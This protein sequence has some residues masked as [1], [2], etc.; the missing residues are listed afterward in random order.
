MMPRAIVSPRQHVD[1]TAAMEDRN[2]VRAIALT[3][4]GAGDPFADVKV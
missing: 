2:R 3:P 4:V 1:V